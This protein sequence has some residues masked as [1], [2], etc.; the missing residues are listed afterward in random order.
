M[1]FIRKAGSGIKLKGFAQNFLKSK[2]VW[3]LGFLILCFLF[4]VF[5]QSPFFAIKNV[6][7]KTQYGPCS[8]LDE[9]QFA[10]PLGENFFFYNTQALAESLKKTFLNR[11]VYVEKVFPGHLS[12]SIEKRKAI[13]VIKLSE[14]QDLYLVDIDGEVIDRVAQSFL[15][16]LTLKDGK[17]EV[18]QRLNEENLQAAKIF[19]L[20]FKAD[21][22]RQAKVEDKKLVVQTGDAITVYFPINRDPQA[23]VGALQ[24]ILTRSRI[25]GKL[26]KLIDL[27]YSKPILKY[28]EV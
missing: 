22:I 4:V 19:H 10:S 20:V 27:R 9:E 1:R 18:G 24:L 8:K 14:G 15:P 16:T 7:C 21:N 26:P 13:V 12:V 28:G 3:V 17:L 6:H 5:L 2:I 11:T 25:E 23:L